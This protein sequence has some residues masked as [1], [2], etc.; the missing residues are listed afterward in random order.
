MERGIAVDTC[1]KEA[2]G[3]IERAF[4]H[5]MGGVPDDDPAVFPTVRLGRAGPVLVEAAHLE[6]DLLVIGATNRNGVANSAVRQLATARS[7]PRVQCCSR[8][9]IDHVMLDLVLRLP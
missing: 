3:V 7:M 9:A 4:E 2:S 8:T 6:E 5:A 1:E